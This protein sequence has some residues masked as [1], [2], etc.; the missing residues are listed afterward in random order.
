M[1]S[2]EGF[3]ITDVYLGL[4]QRAH[5]TIAVSRDFDGNYAVLK[6]TLDPDRIFDNMSSLGGASEVSISIVNQS[7][8]YQL[9]TPHI[10][11]PLEASSFVPPASPAQ[12]AR[13]VN[14]GGKS[15]NYAYSWIPLADWA[16]I[17]QPSPEMHPEGFFSGPLKKLFIIAIPLVL[18]MTWAVFNRANRS[19]ALQMEADRSRIQL[20]HAAKLASVGELAAGIAHE[21][22]N[23]LAVINEEAGL[24]KDLMNPELGKVSPPE[25]LIPHLDTIERSVFRCRDI[26][27]K[28]LGFVRK[29]EVELKSHDLGKI[30]DGVVDGFLGKKAEVSNV[31]VVREYDEAASP[32][33]TDANQLQQVLLNLINNAIDALEGKPGKITIRTFLRAGQ[34]CI[35]ISDTGKGITS[36]QLG[37]IFL[38]FYTTKEVGKGTGLGLSVS[39]G[40]VTNLGGDIE[41]MSRVGKG[42]TFTIVLPKS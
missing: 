34:I 11:T 10:G 29:S 36:E 37:K 40:I 32:I 2:D 1:Q 7:G 33:G 19:V 35:S 12:G 14:I 6:A 26:T 20:E 15:F 8:V 41:V 22:N 30:I 13:E 28:L 42:S 23:P 5:V 27:H 38:P 25:E 3:I 16:L 31:T 17:V 21:I 4:R 39:Y 24:I 9:V 18:L